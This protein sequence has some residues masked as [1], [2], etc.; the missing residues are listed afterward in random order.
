MAIKRSGN[1]L[2]QQ[3]LDVPH[4]KSIES[5]VA[6][7]FD[8]LI[9]L[10]LSGKKPLVIRGLVLNADGMISRNASDL[11][12]NIA[13]SV[14][15]HYGASESGSIFSIS[16]DEASQVLSSSNTNVSGSFA[17]GDNYIGVDFYKTTDTS[18]SDLVKFIDVDLNQEISE[19]V[20]LA[21]TVKY[22]IYISPEPF[23]NTSNVIPIAKVVVSSTLIVSA[24]SDCRPMLSR[25]GTGG[26]N[27]APQ[28]SYSWGTRTEP[29]VTMSS[30]SSSSPFSGEDKSLSSLK[31]WMDAMMTSV[32]ELRGGNSWYSNVYRDNV[33]LAYGP[34]VMANGDNAWLLNGTAV[35]LAKSG[36]TTVTVTLNNQPFVAGSRVK[37]TCANPNFPSGNYTVT[38]TAT[39]TFTYVDSGAAVVASGVAATIDDTAAISG[40]SLIYE[41]G[42][43]SAYNNTIQSGGY[44]VPDGYCLY[45]DLVRENNATIVPQVSTLWSLASSAIPGRR[46]I[47]A[48][49]LGS[50]LYCKDK[51]YEAG[52]T[53]PTATTTALGLVR[54]NAVAGSPTSPVVPVILADGSITIGVSGIG[55]AILG[56]NSSNGQG[57]QGI[58]STGTGVYG[59][60]VNGYGVWG[61]NAAGTA[62]GVFGECF[63]A[64]PAIYG[65]NIST[66]AGVYGQNLSTGYGVNGTSVNGIGVNG[67]STTGL[68]GVRGSSTTGYGVSGTCSTGTSAGVFGESLGAQPGVY[69]SN[70]STGSG[71]AGTA[72]SGYGVRGDSTGNHGTYGATTS[73]SSFG[74]YGQG[75]AGGAGGVSGTAAGSGYGGY[76]ES[77]SVA[78]L[79]AKRGVAT[80]SLSET[81]RLINGHIKFVGTNAAYNDTLPANTLISNQLIKA[82]GQF[83]WNNGAP[84]LTAVGYNLD[85]IASPSAGNVD[86]T[87]K[88]P[89]T[90]GFIIIPVGSAGYTAR[91]TSLFSNRI[92]VQDTTA[93]TPANVNFGTTTGL[94]NFII[95]GLQ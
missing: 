48:W 77:T 72:A 17:S 36:T 61:A 39:N 95:L 78:A 42:S 59:A 53:F 49:R 34:T 58:S 67:V 50:N 66:G 57:V 89:I 82:W 21:R 27:P 38:G 43:A 54:I 14:V 28:G 7:D 51:N 10:S 16:E 32:W 62:A 86:I 94:V 3:R 56:T 47:L 69:G 30:N 35:T 23:E 91:V 26:S 80:N 6:F 93:P 68:A 76:F 90:S 64:Q 60:S 81:L 19:V 44:I 31:D 85:S 75:L 74:V 45:V 33:K 88:T 73:G 71:V 22:K 15:W 5:G 37:I 20:P 24:I 83:T 84:V 70:P 9:G 12:I 87:L 18:T 55:P 52:R 41:N 29:A 8:T 65:Q 4:L 13:G 2:S 11:S 25:L 46:M 1:F 79:A 92:V 40:L 63:G